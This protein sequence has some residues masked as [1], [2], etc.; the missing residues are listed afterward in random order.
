[1]TETQFASATAKGS[2]L[3]AFLGCFVFLLSAGYR[4]VEPHYI[5]WLLRA[6]TLESYLGWMFFRREPWTLPLGHQHA[7]GLEQ[8]S[9]IVYTDSIPLFAFIF[10][11]FSPLLPDQFQY[12]GLWE[13]ISYVLMGFFAWRLA[14]LFTGQLVLKVVTTL[15]FVMSPVMA[16]R[17]NAHIAL[18][19]HWII[20]AALYLYYRP[21]RE[22]AFLH[23]CLLFCVAAM[24]H[25]YLMFMALSV[26]A[27]YC[28]KRLF[29]EHDLKLTA[30]VLRLVVI[31]GTLLGVLWTTG[32]FGDL[33]VSAEG[34]GYYSLNLLGPFVPVG[35]KG[36]VM[37]TVAGAT[38]GQ[39]EGFAY[40]GMGMLFIGVWATF[41]S[42]IIPPFPTKKASGRHWDWPIA[43][44]CLALSLLALSNVVTWGSHVLLT[45]PISAWASN[46]LSIFRASGRMFWPVYYIAMLFFFRL[47]YGRSK[48]E[49][50]AILIIGLLIQAVDLRPFYAGHFALDARTANHLVEHASPVWSFAKI[51]NR[52][53]Y[54]VPGDAPM[55]SSDSMEQ[56]GMMSLAAEHGL[57]IDTAYYG[58]VTSENAQATRTDRH[59]EFFQGKLA[60]DGIYIS[61]ARYLSLLRQSEGLF[62][63]DTGIG[64]IDGYTVVVPK[65]F[66]EANPEQ[67]SL[68]QRPEPADLIEI[69]L[70][71]RQLLKPGGVASRYMIFGWTKQGSIGA[72]SV[73]KSARL[74][75]HIRDCHG[76]YN[77]QL[78]LQAYLPSKTAP[79][80]VD[81]Y[82]AD[83]LV[84]SLNMNKGISNLI[85][86]MHPDSPDSCNYSVELEISNPRSPRDA[87][88]SIDGR[89]LGV[90]LQWLEVDNPMPADRQH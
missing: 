44:L 66:S 68:L 43:V 37:P 55:D 15:L 20:I 86:P 26:F 54:V 33:I 80:Q 39:Y 79:V 71:D 24:V 64:S 36:F 59:A 56:L 52:S 1:M 46:L 12:A 32:Y 18:S 53:L 5:G 85:L 58:R 25:A 41:R 9:S 3:G 28:M 77:L 23:W 13:L 72:W 14:S 76:T 48:A 61:N 63:Q 70:G 7:L 21:L 57:A 60:S 82:N 89:K 62:P 90:L 30:L 34:F 73:G 4:I 8:A 88:Q 51:Q 16:L 47:L 17:V 75:F 29:V 38:H 49:A 42:G 87:G 83:Q 69:Q 2:I 40:L 67:R 65:W 6:D 10:K 78:S 74:G 81:F 50:T 19:S 22:R 84:Q 31:G 27:A 45:I 35:G 11:A